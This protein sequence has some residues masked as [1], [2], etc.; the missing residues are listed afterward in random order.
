MYYLVLKDTQGRIIARSERTFVTKVSAELEKERLMSMNAIMPRN[1]GVKKEKRHY[2]L[3][4]LD[5]NKKIGQRDTAY[6]TFA[7]AE[8]L[9]QQIASVSPINAD[10][11]RKVHA[12]IEEGRAIGKYVLEGWS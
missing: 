11:I 12:T 2:V 6:K 10:N 4:L 1:F 9:Q 3:S 7:E 8:R 5:Q